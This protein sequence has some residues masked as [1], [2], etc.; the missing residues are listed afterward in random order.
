MKMG[1]EGKQA[2]QQEKEKKGES[3]GGKSRR[4]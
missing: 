4:G 2:R 3:D 1:G